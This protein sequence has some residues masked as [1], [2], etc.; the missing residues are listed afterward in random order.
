FVDVNTP[1]NGVA[2]AVDESKTNFVYALHA[3][4]GYKV[5][6]SLTMELA[7]RYVHF[8]DVQ[9]GDLRT[10]TG[11]NNVN[12]PMLFRGLE[13]HD[14]KLGVRWTCCEPAAPVAPPILTRR[15]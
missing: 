5:S 7:Y 3:G 8:G 9:S 12:N 6:N 10:F 14:L 1:N 2:F 13:S 4:L 15:G 11:V